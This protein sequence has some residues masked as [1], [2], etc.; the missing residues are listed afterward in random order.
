MPDG[1]SGTSMPKPLCVI[2][3]FLSE[4]KNSTGSSIVIICLL[5]VLLIFSIIDAIV[6]DL[7]EPVAPVIKRMPEL[8]SVNCWIEGGSINCSN[9]GMSYGISLIVIFGIPKSLQ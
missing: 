8:H 3:Q 4:Y 6:V 7:P 5:C 2:K 1:K 9:V